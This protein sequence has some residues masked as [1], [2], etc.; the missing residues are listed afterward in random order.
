MKLHHLNEHEA[1]RALQKAQIAL[2]PLGAV[3]PHG[4]HLPLDTDNLLAERFCA[5]LDE[6]LGEC[7][8]SL[9]VISYSQVWSLR[10]HAG[11]IDI[12]NDR[13]TSML[14]SLAENMASYGITTT[15]VI[16]AHYGNFD[17]IKAA[18]RQLK[19]KGITLLSYSWA[20]M[21][22]EVKKRQHS[23]VAYPGY[24]HADEVETSL[25]LAL[26]PEFVTM[27]NARAHYPV[28]PPNFRYQP[29][30]WTEFSDYAVLGDPTK[31]SEEKGS[32]FVQQAL[33]T[34]LASIRHHL[35]QGA[36]DDRKSID[37]R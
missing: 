28:F 14:V 3:E 1:R 31:A 29:I 27:A 6:Q 2:L 13:L 8:L 32:A 22:Q 5:R 25:M 23:A 20:G 15:A 34:T 16:N 4:D 36:A 12:G 33:E 9:P 17:A 7:A 24:M 10:G 11:A 21:E 19:E 35:T 18:S 26:A 37:K 30:R